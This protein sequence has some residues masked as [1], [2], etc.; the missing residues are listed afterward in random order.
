MWFRLLDNVNDQRILTHSGSNMSL[1]HLAFD[2]SS[3]TDNCTLR[4]LE[5]I[6]MA[7]EFRSVMRFPVRSGARAPQS[8]KVSVNNFV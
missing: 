2:C 4:K 7:C 1:I 8:E 6:C 5:S 3:F